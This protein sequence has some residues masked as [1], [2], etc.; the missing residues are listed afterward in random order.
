MEKKQEELSRT[1]DKDKKE[2]SKKKWVYII[3]SLVIIGLIGIFIYMLVNNKSAIKQVN[4]F[5][6]AV[7]KDKY[8]KVSEMLSTNDQKVSKTDAKHFIDYMKKES[9]HSKFEKEINGIKSDIRNDKTSDVDLGN[10]TDKHNRSI[11]EVKKNGTKMFFFEKISFSPNYIP[12]YV[13]GAQ[14]DVDYIYT[15]SNDKKTSVTVPKGKVTKIDNFMVGSYNIDAMKSYKNSIVKDDIDGKININTDRV[16]KDNKSMVTEDFEE[17]WFKVNMMNSDELSD[18]KLYIN[19]TETEYKKEKTYGRFPAAESIELY[20]KGKLNE[21]TFETESE[22]VS[23][24]KHDEPQFIDLS[25][26]KSEIKKEK[27]KMNK[28]KNEVSKFMKDYTESLNKAYKEVEFGEVKSYFKNDTEVSKHIK[29]MVESKNKSK[30]KAPSIE[31]V[32]KDGE[33]TKVILTKEDKE[34]NKIKSEYVLVK[35][36]ETYKIVSYKD[37]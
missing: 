33:K 19:D 9:N 3:I 11:V 36:G 24:N 25:F 1:E 4:E 21:K 31:S 7:N 37:I 6:K 29:S 17:A 34:G 27:D 16:N 23:N 10:I 13:K 28:E 26:R 18:V 5:D 14:E 2:V 15:N 12:V 22:F 32:N 30:Y 20:A 8:Q 35:S